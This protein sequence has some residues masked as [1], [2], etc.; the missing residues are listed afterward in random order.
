M[1]FR[2]NKRSPQWSAP[3]LRCCR[4][5]SAGRSKCRGQRR[6]LCSPL[7][8]AIY[9][10]PM[11]LDQVHAI[12]FVDMPSLHFSCDSASSLPPAAT[13]RSLLVWLACAG[14]LGRGIDKGYS[15]VICL[16]SPSISRASKFELCHQLPFG[17]FRSIEIIE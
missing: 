2:H 14:N 17:C 16:S 1:I 10:L 15:T 12:F 3:T 8:S 5:R 9:S 7:S 4:C 11:T 6:R 13:H